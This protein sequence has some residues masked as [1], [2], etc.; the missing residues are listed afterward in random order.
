P[1]V[2]YLASDAAKDVNGHIF[3]AAGYNVALMSQPKIIK[4]L[5]ADHRWTVEELCDLIPR[6]FEAELVENPNQPGFNA[7]IAQLDASEGQGFWGTKLEPYGEQ[8]W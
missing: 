5:R 6:A 8:I 2:T 3:S 1:I 7:R 4:T